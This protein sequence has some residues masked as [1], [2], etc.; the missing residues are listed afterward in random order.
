MDYKIAQLALQEHHLAE[1]LQSLGTAVVTSAFGSLSRPVL[2]TQMRR[3]VQ[4]EAMN[5]RAVD[6]AR[7]LESKDSLTDA[8]SFIEETVKEFS[9]VPMEEASLLGEGPEDQDRSAAVAAAS[10]A[11]SRMSCDELQAHGVTTGSIKYSKHV[12]RIPYALCLEW[13]VRDGEDKYRFG[14]LKGHGQLA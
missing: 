3:A 8:V 10:S 5:T 1:T 13:T 7:R 6:L 4:D 14:S 12:Y 9:A 2:A 11:F